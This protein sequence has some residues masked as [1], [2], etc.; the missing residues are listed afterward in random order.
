[1]RRGSSL[2]KS[3]RP[4]AP[5][6]ELFLICACKIGDVISFEQ[7]RGL[8]ASSRASRSKQTKAPSTKRKAVVD[9][10]EEASDEEEEVGKKPRVC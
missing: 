3:V 1:M 2:K 9:S 4:C 8:A 6:F 7:E 5:T 10:D